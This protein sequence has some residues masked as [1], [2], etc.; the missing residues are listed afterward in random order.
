M[1]RLKNKTKSI[2][3]AIISNSFA[4]C[5]TLANLGQPWSPWYL[6]L[7]TIMDIGGYY[8]LIFGGPHTITLLKSRL[9]LPIFYLS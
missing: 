4:M 5:F 9:T 8:Q 1:E 3:D 6:G 2:L 7:E